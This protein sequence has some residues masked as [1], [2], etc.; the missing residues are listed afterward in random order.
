M[1][2][3]CHFVLNKPNATYIGGEIISGTIQ[4]NTTSAKDVREVNIIFLGESKVKWKEMQS[5][6][7]QTY[8]GHELHIADKTLVHGEGI[9]PAGTH[10]YSF[11]ITLPTECPSSIET[12]YGRVRYE[13]ILKLDHT[14]GFDNAFKQQITVLKPV[15]L[16]LNPSYKLPLSCEDINIDCWPCS[17][18]TVGCSLEIPFGAYVP[19]QLVKYTLI[20][21]NQ[22]H[23]DTYGYCYEF[24]KKITYTATEFSSKEKKYKRKVLITK[25]FNDQC[26]RYTNRCFEGDFTIPSI[27]ST[28]DSKNILCVE[29]SFK[30]TVY[31]SG[32]RNDCVLKIPIVIGTIPI[33]ESLE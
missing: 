9:L 2:S 15:D 23:S 7:N 14:F 26:I 25:H 27:P 18:G 20:I 4:L 8:R 28:T 21:N 3:V 10:T 30:V 31:I 13:I 11:N 12:K 19:G 32:C 29:Y 33:R 1:P 24:K 17:S 5:K 6:H 22:S 16:N